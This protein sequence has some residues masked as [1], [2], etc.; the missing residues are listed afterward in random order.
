MT[1]AP[2]LTAYQPGDDLIYRERESDPSERVIL[3]SREQKRSPR[4][5]V[6]FTEGERPGSRAWVPGTRIHGAWRDV[7]AFDAYSAA[8]EHLRADD[9]LTDIESY[10]I[11][12]VYRLLLPRE[13]GDMIWQPIHHATRIEDPEALEGLVAGPLAD[14]LAPFA[15]LEDDGALLV[16]PNA[17]SELAEALCRTQ[18][19]R[20]SEWVLEE[21][22]R[23]RIW[24]KKGKPTGVDG[25]PRGTSPDWE[26]RRYRETDR[27][28]YELIRSWCGHRAVTAHERRVAAEAEVHRLE[29]L[30]TDAIDALR[31]GWGVQAD[32]FEERLDRDRI[33]AETIRPLVERPLDPSEIPVRIEDRTRGRWGG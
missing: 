20:V 29:V 3:C 17:S 15:T 1:S 18:P 10:A 4:V 22:D 30:V 7:A 26:W 2:D 27:P 25:E 19:A 6:E 5:E 13:V 33:T 9:D 14:L 24:T 31:K 21:E 16:S 23:Q 12:D 32:L 11:A 8:V 28:M